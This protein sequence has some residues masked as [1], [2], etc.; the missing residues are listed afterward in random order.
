V[1]ILGGLAVVDSGE[2]DWK[3]VGI[4]VDHP[5]AVGKTDLTTDEKLMIK[6]WA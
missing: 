5:D 6:W 2:M 4:R 1:K 3:L